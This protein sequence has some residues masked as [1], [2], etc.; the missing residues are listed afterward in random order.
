LPRGPTPRS[1]G[2]IRCWRC[3]APRSWPRWPTWIPATSHLITA[4]VAFAV[5]ALEQRGLRRFELAIAALFGVVL[6]GFAYDLTA[7]GAEPADIAAGLVSRFADGPSVVLAVGIVGATVMPHVVYLHSALTARQAG[8][9]SDIPTSGRL[10]SL[11]LDVVLALGAASLVNL[12]MLAMAA[13]LMH[14]T[15]GARSCHFSLAGGRGW[16]GCRR[17]GECP[18]S[19]VWRGLLRQS[20]Q[21]A[22][23]SRPPPTAVPP[24]TGHSR[25]VANY[26]HNG[27]INASPTL[28]L[29]IAC[30]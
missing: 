19:R 3:S 27:Q 1:R 21:V 15:G 8:D 12:A 22:G 29:G 11:R 6:L 30:T 9:T 25:R 23:I 26:P 16:C 28:F 2:G 20:P 10:R 17:G 18:V 14:R 24:L 7:I 13:A 4:F 5:L